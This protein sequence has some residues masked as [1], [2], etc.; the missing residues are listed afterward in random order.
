MSNSSPLSIFNVEMEKDLIAALFV[1]DGEIIPDVA[2]IISVDD[3]YRPEHRLIYKAVLD[4]YNKNG[5]CDLTS[6]VDLLRSNGKLKTNDNP[7]GLELEYIFGIWERQHNNYFALN[8]ARDI[9]E[10]AEKRRLLDSLRTIA[11]DTTNGIPSIEELQAKVTDLALSFA[12]YKSES[13]LNNLSEYLAQD[14][15]SDVEREKL[16]ADRKTGFDNLDDKQNFLP[17]VYVIGAEPALG[18]TTFAWQLAEQL[19]EGGEHCIFC[20]YEMSK[21]EMASKTLAR[22]AFQANEPSFL[23]STDIRKGGFSDTVNMARFEL[24][25]GEKINL[26]IMEIADETSID[27]L[28]ALL[29]PI[30]K[31]DDK[32]PIVFIDY[33]QIAAKAGKS[34]A[35]NKDDLKSGIDAVLRKLKLFQ[36]DTGTTF[37]VVSSFNRSNYNSTAAFE[38]FKES[39]GIEYS[40]DVIFALQLHAV[41][42]FKDAAGAQK[43]RE[44]INKAKKQQ[45]REMVL[46]CL[47]N[48]FGNNY[49]CY[50]KYYSAH[51]YFCAC[52][53][54]E[55][56]NDSDNQQPT[57]DNSLDAQDD[58]KE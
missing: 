1:K 38:S 37:F 39:G 6:V 34:A 31:S 50:F 29:Y 51:D 17:G 49:N 22:R 30:C 8:H 53:E 43:I 26:D 11:T 14:F 52:D 25:Y 3:F 7:K 42:K 5:N 10:H 41:T 9:K 27:K 56:K 2:A 4:V 23:S 57:K 35:D 33:L 13:A 48:R 32:P 21:L 45:P 12:K 15:N 36:R 40:A 54:S 44:I 58:D 20:S 47:K 16:H 28:L 18:K 24:A 55:F 19:A 46:Q